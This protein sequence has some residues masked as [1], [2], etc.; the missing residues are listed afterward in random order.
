MNSKV[1][2]IL[3]LL[4]MHFCCAN[5]DIVSIVRSS[6]ATISNW[7][8]YYI[9]PLWTTTFTTPTS[10]PPDTGITFYEHEDITHSPSTQD[11]NV[12][13]MDFNEDQVYL[14][15]DVS[16]FPTIFIRVLLHFPNDG[17]NVNGLFM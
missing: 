13:L 11:E 10:L 5:S 6:A 16:A 1:L 14:C 15:S 2:N 3:I 8:G 12:V 4:A 17:V 9:K 7:Y